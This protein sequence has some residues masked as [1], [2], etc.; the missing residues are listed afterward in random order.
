V[1]QRVVVVILTSVVVHNILFIP[2]ARADEN[3]WN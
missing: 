3:S 2:G 1:F